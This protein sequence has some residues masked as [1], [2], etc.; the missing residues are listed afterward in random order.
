MGEAVVG[1]VV[2]GEDE[3]GIEAD[4]VTMRGIIMETIKATTKVLDLMHICLFLYMML[5]YV[6]DYQ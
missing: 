4:M 3:V 2:E 1:I 6:S 5:I